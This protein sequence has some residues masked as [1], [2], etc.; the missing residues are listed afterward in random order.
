M[1]CVLYCLAFLLATP[2]LAQDE[3]TAVREVID[4]FVYEYEYER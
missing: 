1:K 4:R 3:K 2:L